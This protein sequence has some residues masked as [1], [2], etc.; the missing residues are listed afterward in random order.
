MKATI[1]T[2]FT[3]IT[4]SVNAQTDSSYNKKQDTIKIGNMV[5]VGANGTK[6]V[7]KVSW[8][9]DSANKR[10]KRNG[11]YIKSFND[12]I[13]SINDD[14]VK[15]GRINIINKNES[16]DPHFKTLVKIGDAS[17]GKE[18]G[19]EMGWIKGDF[20]KTRISI[21]KG[22]KENK[23]IMTNWWILDLGFANYTDKTEP[24]YYAIPMNGFMPK[25]VTSNDLKLNNVKSSNVNIWIVQQ[26]ASLYKHYLN[27]KYGVG[28]EM[29]NFRFEQPISFSKA[30]N[31]IPY[32]DNVTF[33][34]NKLFV[35]YLTVPVQLNFQSNPDN[36]RSFY[37]SI[38]VSTG[39]LLQ[40]H[41]K[42]ISEER[43]KRKLNGNFNLNNFKMA[44][45]GELGIGNIRLYG[46]F[47]TT[48]LFD[49]NLTHFDMTPFAVGVR[50]S[51]F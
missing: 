15:V 38:G 29:Y 11:I 24:V 31:S 43:G 50:F 40:S 28:F 46:S 12:T 13:V 45:I 14:T 17:Y 44:T 49:K 26:K 34:K 1:L 39:Y 30:P 21:E 27:L 48:N 2:A 16:E 32:F 8:N 5:I 42:Q 19:G 33:S 47:N 25:Y 3:L 37:A 4:L 51:K 9:H 18:K 23:R 41:T 22:K 6:E 10:N 7:D 36:S 20:K 35:E